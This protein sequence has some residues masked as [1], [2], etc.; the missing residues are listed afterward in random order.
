MPGYLP[1]TNEQVT[2]CARSFGH[3]QAAEADVGLHPH[4]EMPQALRQ[5]HRLGP[6]EL[7]GRHGWPSRWP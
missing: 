5:R 3:P 2:G 4:T 7:A 1:R 6:D